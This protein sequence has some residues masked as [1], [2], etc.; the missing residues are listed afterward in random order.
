MKPLVSI[1][2]ATY[3]RKELLRECLQSIKEQTFKDFEIILIDDGS[4]DGTEELSSMVD[5]YEKI[6]KSGISKARNRSLELMSGKYFFVIDSDDKL[7]PTCIE[8]HVKLMDKGNDLVF[9]FYEYFGEGMAPGS[10]AIY[11]KQTF[12]QC[13]R[14]KDI[15]HVALYRTETL[16][17]FRYDETLKSAVDYDYILDILS[18]FPSI[19]I[20]VI[21]KPLYLYRIGHK[22]ERGTFAQ[23]QAVGI[24]RKKYQKKYEAT[25]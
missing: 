15:P 21:E 9:C 8:E 13:Y 24:I 25:I 22:Q 16:G 14:K 2:I 12:S 3:N 1:L 17:G 6:P 19:K 5:I 10:R 11:S 20:A 4:T 18:K 7:R 23:T